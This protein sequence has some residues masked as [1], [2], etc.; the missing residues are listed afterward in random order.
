MRIFNE[1]IGKQ[2]PSCEPNGPGGPVLVGFNGV[3]PLSQEAISE[4]SRIDRVQRNLKLGGNTDMKVR[5]K[6]IFISA[7][8]FLFWE[9]IEEENEI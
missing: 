5:P 3:P 8:G 2:P 4:Q 1:L 9:I 7:W 6:L